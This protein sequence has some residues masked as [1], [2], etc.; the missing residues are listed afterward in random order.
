MSDILTLDFNALP[1]AVKDRFIAITT[2]N[3]GPAPLLSQKTSSKSKIVG[4]SFLFVLLAIVTF[5]VIIAGIGDYSLDL[6]IHDWIYVLVFYVPVG[7]LTLW[8]L[9][10]IVMRLVVGSPYPFQPGRY[11]FPTDFVDARNGQLRV[12]PSRLLSDFRIVH[13]HTNGRYTHT[14]VTFIF[15]GATEQFSVN[16]QQAAEAAVNAYLQSQRTL[17]QAAQAQDW[18]TI[19]NMDPFFEC[20]R[21][22]IW[23]QQNMPG[24]TG[25]KVKTIPV[26]FRWKPAIAAV[27]ALFLCAPIALAR[28]LVSDEIMFSS[29]KK[30]DTESA[31]GAYVRHG[32]RHMDEA[33]LAQPIAAFRE[34]RA[35]GT[36]S[37]MRHV[38]KTYPGSSVESDA[39]AAMH[40]LY[41]AALS[42]FRAKASTS[43][44]RMLPFMERLIA[45]MEENDT[46][47]VRVVFS[48]PTNGA[49]SEADTYFKGKYS[50]TGKIIEPIAPYFGAESSAPREAE[51]VTGLNTAF[52]TIFPTDLLTLEQS[53]SDS[54]DGDKDP[55]IAI[56]YGVGPS[57]DAYVSDDGSRIFVG[58]DV[59]FTMKMRIPNDARDFDF[60]LKVSPPDHFRYR[61]D[62]DGSQ[63]EA[64]YNAMAQRAFDEFSTKLKAIFFKDAE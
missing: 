33:K 58:I 34:A 64:A 13:M 2:G 49:L 14:Q 4:L 16:G 28:N 3:A 38:L 56:V 10:T 59:G 21:T 6:G 9:L 44:P 26:F 41:T 42:D 20:R 27:L 53:K 40:E 15:Q 30:D 50:G 12:V 48:P 47:T 51:I 25:P 61:Y 19:S 62:R 23:Q 18:Q 5:V 43:D 39:R 35:K 31:Y 52:A 24:D 8:V 57:G 11:L 29:A 46:A 17:S 37:A 60:D 55:K 32:W 7:F 36:V 22:G 1:R 45:Y 54:S 63:A